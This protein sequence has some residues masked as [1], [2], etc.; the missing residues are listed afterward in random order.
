MDIGPNIDTILR[1]SEIIGTISSPS[2]NL[3]LNIDIFEN[4]I[5]KKLIGELVVFKYVQDGQ[6]QYSIA[7]IIEIELKNFLLEDPTIKSIARKKGQVNAISSIQDIHIGKILCGS[8]FADVEDSFEQ[9]LLGTVPPTGTSVYKVDDRILNLLLSKQ[10]DNVFYLGHSYGS[11]T[12]LPM[13][14]KHFGHGINGAGEAYH[15]GIFGITGS[16][17]STLAKMIMTAYAKHN[18]MGILILDPVGEFAKTM[19]ENSTNIPSNNK[20]QFNL[21]LKQI[22]Q[23]NNK[24]F[25][26][27][28][29]R[30]IVLDRWALFSEILSESKFFPRLTI[31]NPNK[32]F[33]VDTIVSRIREKDKVRLKELIERA[34]FDKVISHLYD[35]EVLRQIYSSYEP[36]KRVKETLDEID[37]DDLYNNIWKSFS[38]LFNDQRANSIKVDNL[39]KKFQNEKPVIV[40]DLSMPY[41]LT[42]KNLTY[43][44]ENIQFLILK[45]IMDG[46]IDLGEENWHGNSFLN[47]L[48]VLDEAHRFATREKTDNINLEELRMKLL[49]AVRT[50]RKYGLGWMFLSTSLSSI[51]REILQQLRIVFYGFG[52]SLGSDLIAL[53]EMV[54]DPKSIQLYQSFTDPA[55]SFSTVSRKYSFMSRGPIS[56][57]SFSGAPLFFNAFNSTDIFIRENNL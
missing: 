19:V 4:A 22:F 33:A 46:L 9:S 17:K 2:S 12:K 45:R 6:S 53:K 15:L 26:V 25:E 7:Q 32:Q 37:K 16:G 39:L 31:K 35:D 38:N 11:K 42:A 30:N 8:V 10:K 23:D 27:V 52:L 56:P 29:I 40:I 34:T 57:L 21:N 55:S 44:N 43:W 41:D 48:V 5:S 13:W 28:N 51:H 1:N 49:D 14:F 36:R 50:T 3:E 20:T 18:E 24:K 54:S 47:T